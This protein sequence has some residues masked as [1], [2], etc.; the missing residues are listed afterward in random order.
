MAASTA[1]ILF[2][3]GLPENIQIDA[4]GGSGYFY[5]SEKCYNP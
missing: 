1:A 4:A 5:F 3:T 2:F